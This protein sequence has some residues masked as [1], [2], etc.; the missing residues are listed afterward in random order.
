V[1][2][3]YLGREAERFEGDVPPLELPVGTTLTVRGRATRKLGEAVLQRGDGSSRI[4][5]EVTA[6]R[7][8]GRWTPR[9]SGVY[10]W[11]LTDRTGGGLASAPPPLEITIV[12]DAAPTVDITFPGVDTVLGP[13][14]Q[15]VIVADARDDHGLVDARLVSWRVS[16]LG[17][18]EAPVEEKLALEGD[19]ERG[20]VRGIL[21]ATRRGLLPGDEIHYHVRVTDNSPR[22]QTA[23]SPTYVL[24]LP[25]LTELRERAE[26]QTE[27]MVA[28]AEALTQSAKE[29]EQS[30]RE[31]AR[32]SANSRRGGASASVNR[33]GR[34]GRSGGSEGG[35]PGGQ[36]NLG[37]QEVE[38]ARQLLDRQESMVRRVEEM[39]E[40]TAALERAMQEAG[41]QDPALQERLREIRELYDQVLSPELKEQMEELR[42]SLDQMDPEE[43]QR[44]LEQLAQRQAE[45]RQQ[46]EQSL[47]LLR[48][49]AAEQEMNA[50]ARE[51]QEL[52]TQQQ[53]LA[54][55]MKRE[56]APSP[57]R[58]A[59]QQELSRQADALQRA[60]ESLAQKLGKQGET[61]AAAQAG[62]AGQSVEQARRA[63]DRAAQQ[64]RQPNGAQAGQQAGATGQQA[65]AELEQAA[66]TLESAR[67]SMA[68]AWRDEVQESVQQAANEALALAQRQNELLEQ[69]REAQRQQDQ[70]GRQQGAS[71]G[72]PSSGEQGQQQGAREGQTGSQGERPQQG[73]DPQQGQQ[74]QGS[75][76]GQQGQQGRQGQSGQQGQSG[77]QGQSGKQGRQGKQGGGAGQRGDQAG[78]QVGPTGQRPS[79]QSGQ[80]GQGGQ[81]NQGN[82][83][84]EGNQGHQS[85][86]MDL[87]SL[88]SEQAALQQGLEALGRNL[89][90]AGRRS[91]MVDRE[92]GAAL[93]RAM[94]SMQQTLEA[95][96]GRDGQSRMPIEE[97][98]QTVEALNRLALS[99]LANS[100][101]IEQAQSGTGLQEALQQ[102][103]ELAKQQGALNG[104]TNSLLPLELG[105]Q[106]M[107]AQ[108]QRLAQTQRDIAKKLGGMN[109][110]TGGSDDLLGELDALAREAEEIARELGGGRLTPELLARQERLFHRLLDA[111]RTL[112]RE[113][114]SDERVGERPGDVAPSLAPALDAALLNGGPRYPVPG[115]EALRALPPAY[116]KLILE[117]FDRLNRREAEA[118]SRRGGGAAERESR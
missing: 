42:R 27:A 113:E 98:E 6:D 12:E 38:Q 72:Q 35:S 80:G 111:G 91:A 44:A 52:A 89:E 93:G 83:G 103:A 14:M 59:Q 3:G 18:S 30:T 16:A 22:R 7:F 67:E 77:E 71:Q 88:R 63:M 29:L 97:A 36:E 70:A 37:Y 45:F 43:V 58:I 33:S 4:A 78:G 53:A 74:G 50:L 95:M 73:K 40:R 94:L 109:D 82:Q 24:R 19:A 84:P 23:I 107:G 57:E 47:E 48:R 13:S 46:V 39:R 92:V 75:Q 114:Y 41:L 1:Y 21:D 87:Q 64:A 15:Q 9:S 118:G 81:G 20:I 117:Y 102:L 5:L 100:E 90:E 28:D 62:Q 2:P 108:M 105:P 104:Q 56:G 115:P 85:G 32:R 66:K 96:G 31:L 49:A 106:A 69:M 54:E 101:K 55:A 8:V 68:Q 11:H 110:M 17:G 26:S 65:A 112:E 10:H 76:Q 51:A 79:G 25:G 34:S 99:L 86:E 116:R 60:L 61:Q